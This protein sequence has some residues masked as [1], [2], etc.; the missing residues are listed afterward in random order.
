MPGGTGRY[1]CCDVVNR[2]VALWKGAVLRRHAR[3]RLIK[4]DA[5][6]GKPLWTVDTVENHNKAYTITGAPRVVDG[7]VAHRQLAAR[8]TIPAVTSPPTIRI[9]QLVGASM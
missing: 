7:L 8:N 5:A 2:G 3:G 9:G 1:A 6:T 4:L